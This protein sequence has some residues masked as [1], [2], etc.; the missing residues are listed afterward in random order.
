MLVWIVQSGEELPGIDPGAREWRCSMLAKALIAKG[1]NVLWWG[2]TFNHARKTHRF[3][4]PRTIEMMPRW[5]I[6]LLHGPGYKQNRSPKRLLHNR[7]L[8]SAFAQE[9]QHVQRPDILFVSLPILE[10]AEQSVLYAKRMKVPVVIDIRDLWPDHY[11]TLVPPLFRRTFRAM[12]FTEFRRVRRILHEAAGI[13]SISASFLEWGLKYAGR[14]QGPT[15]K[16]FPMGYPSNPF[17]QEEILDK[18][19]EIVTTYGIKTNGLVI[20]FAGSLNSIFDFD[21]VIKAARIL[22]RKRES[23]VQFIVAGDGSL[24]RNIRTAAR[25][26]KN[27]VFTGWVDHLTIAAIHGLASAGLAP[28]AVG[29]S[30]SGSLP[31]KAFEYMAFGLPILSSHQG[32]L[33][34]LIR[35]KRIGL[36]YRSGRPESL[37]EKIY[38]MM[39]HPDELQ[40][41]SKRSQSLYNIEY[42]SDIIY[43]KMVDFLEKIA[44]SAQDEA[45]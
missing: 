11:L 18:Q 6:R 38:W 15:D 42:R 44:Q 37:V 26:L 24:G 19:K 8:A 45:I 1:H 30:V 10:L 32:D 21:T 5:K 3:N 12:L 31:N 14:H 20:S 27:M 43:A 22:E 4:G 35:N 40:A 39:E 9:I 34:Y 23:N 25:G 17:T 7:K 13:T 28:Y 41:M 33:E 29:G 36:Q 2:S 16:V